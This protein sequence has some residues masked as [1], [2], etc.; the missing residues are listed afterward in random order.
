[1]QGLTVISSFGAADFFI[2]DPSAFGDREYNN[3]N[4][5]KFLQSNLYLSNSFGHLVADFSCGSIGS[6]TA[7]RIDASTTGERASKA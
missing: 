6:K 4:G 1:M 3:Q 2:F 5:N 7:L